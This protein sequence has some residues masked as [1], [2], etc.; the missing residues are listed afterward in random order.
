MHTLGKSSTPQSLHHPSLYLSVEDKKIRKRS[1]GQVLA[2]PAAA[3]PCPPVG[4]P[5]GNLWSKGLHLGI[6]YSLQP[7]GTPQ[8]LARQQS[9]ATKSMTIWVLNSV[10]LCVAQVN[11][12]SR[13]S[14]HI[15]LLFGLQFP[16]R[17]VLSVLWSSNTT[18]S[19]RLGGICCHVS[20]LEVMLFRYQN[21]VPINAWMCLL[22]GWVH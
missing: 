19:A 8:P 20:M 22:E 17:P 3:V 18:V 5:S 1:L 16:G 21:L 4:G 14:L 13:P 2:A 11:K 6:N 15:C 12:F 7:P 10:S 9:A